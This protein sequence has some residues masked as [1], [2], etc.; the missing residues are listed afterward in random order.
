MAAVADIAVFA[1]HVGYARRR[2]W[3]ACGLSAPV[4]AQAAALLAT[5]GRELRGSQSPPDVSL[6]AVPTAVAAAVPALAMGAATH[7]ELELYNGVH[8]H[9]CGDA[10]RRAAQNGLPGADLLRLQEGKRLGDRGR[11]RAWNPPREAAEAAPRNKYFAR[12]GED[13]AYLR[14]CRGFGARLGSRLARAL[15]AAP[16]P[17]PMPANARHAAAVE[18]S[19][20]STLGDGQASDRAAAVAAPSV[21]LRADAQPFPPLGP[22]WDVVGS[23]QRF[24]PEAV[25]TTDPAT[26]WRE[27]EHVAV[28]Y[29]SSPQAWW[30]PE[31]RLQ[32]IAVNALKYV[33]VEVTKVVHDVW[34]RPPPKPRGLPLVGSKSWARLGWLDKGHEGE[35]MATGDTVADVAEEEPPAC[36]ELE[37]PAPAA[38]GG[39]FDKAIEAITRVSS[40]CAAAGVASG[41]DETDW[42]LV[43]RA[44]KVA[45]NSHTVSLTW[46]DA[47]LCALLGAGLEAIEQSLTSTE[48]FDAIQLQLQ[49]RIVKEIA[50]V[51]V[52]TKGHPLRMKAVP[53]VYECD[54]CGADIPR[55]QPAGMCARCD[56]SLCAAC[57]RVRRR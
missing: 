43:S 12:Y 47:T 30:L 27:L 42:D 32:F 1:A 31:V 20:K 45:L 11:H 51:G 49:D 29:G 46:G 25:P 5:L 15:D 4:R 44:T 40:S 2:A 16:T 21:P 6:V 50:P 39:L 3:K 48:H 37:L 53:A 9:N 35:A 33:V 7:Q 14:G 23:A 13:S 52:C 18:A 26:T 17:P 55:S 56:F 22:P 36:T 8:D 24:W 57:N 34:D 19:L 38:N 54:A 10:M 28:Y 41:S